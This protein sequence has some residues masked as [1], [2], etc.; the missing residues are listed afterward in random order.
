M[1]KN[2]QIRNTFQQQP[3]PPK[4]DSRPVGRTYTVSVFHPRVL[5][6][7]LLNP[8]ANHSTHDG[9]AGGH[10]PSLITLLGILKEGHKTIVQSNRCLTGMLFLWDENRES[11]CIA[12]GPCHSHLT[13]SIHSPVYPP[14]PP[15]RRKLDQYL[16]TSQSSIYPLHKRYISTYCIQSTAYKLSGCKEFLHKR[17]FH[18]DRNQDKLTNI[19]IRWSK[20]R[21]QNGQRKEIF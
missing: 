9:L 14:L 13:G 17:H 11:L 21:V 10:T 15:S 20:L 6:V 3:G 16:R 5:P 7:F 18:S 2:Q 19:C 4:M 1:F 12:G 8:N